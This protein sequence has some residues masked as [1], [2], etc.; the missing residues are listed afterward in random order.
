MTSC[1]TIRPE[2]V[3]GT[4]DYCAHVLLHSVE[5]CVSDLRSA[6]ER[7]AQE[8]AKLHDAKTQR[9]RDKITAKVKELRVTYKKQKFVDEFEALDTAQKKE[10]YLLQLDKRKREKFLGQLHGLVNWDGTKDFS[11]VDAELKR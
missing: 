3:L 5:L 2:A 8:T 7:L 11:K 10:E 6:W 4:L 9:K 1:D